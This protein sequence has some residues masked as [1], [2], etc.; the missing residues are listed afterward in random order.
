MKWA[1]EL[2][3]IYIN[4]EIALLSRYLAQTGHGNIE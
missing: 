4:P 3:Q 1:V 2:G